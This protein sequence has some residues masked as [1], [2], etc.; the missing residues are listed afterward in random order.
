MISSSRRTTLLCLLLG[1]VTLAVYWPV[2]H[3]RFINYDDPKYVVENPRVASGLTWPNVGWAFQTGH[4]SNWHPLTWLSHMLDVQLF[5][6]DP[7]WHHFTSLLFHTANTLLLFLL[8]Q[9]LTG[10]PWRS[11]SVA[12]LFALHPLHVESVAWVAERKDVLSTF[13]F[14]LTLWAYARYV[15]LQSPKSKVQSPKSVVGGS[16][17]VFYLLALTFFALGLMSKPMLVTLPFLLLLLDYWPLR[18][19]QIENQNSKFR[20]LLPLLLEKLPF[21]VL[22]TASCLVTFVVQ[23]R[24]VA[25][26]EGFPVEDRLINAL[27]SYFRYLAKTVWPANLAPFYPLP[28]MQHLGFDQWPAWLVLAAVFSLAAITGLALRAWRRQPW[29][30]TGWLWFLGTLV[31]VIGLVQAGSQAMADRYSYI[32]LIG[33]FIALVWSAAEL[34]PARSGRNKAGLAAVGVLALA[35]CAALTRKQ[36]N[37]WRDDFALFG[38]TLAVTTENSVPAHYCLGLAF[39]KQG[40]YD[41]AIPHF[42]AVLQLASNMT[43]AHY[44]LGLCL[45]S[46]GKFEEAM[47]AYQAAL[48][49]NPGHA[50]ARNNLAVTLL[51]LGRLDEAAA[52]FAELARLE[53]ASPDPLCSLGGLLLRQRKFAQAETQFAAAVRRQPDFIPALLGLGRALAARGEFA[54]AEARFREVLLLSPTHAEAQADLA[55]AQAGDAQTNA[56]ATWPNEA[57]AKTHEDQGLLYARLG[58]LEEA[59]REF[60]EQL[61]LQPDAQ[62]HYNVALARVMQGNLKEAAT[63]YEEAVKLKPDWPIA[64]NDLAWIRATAPL[65][66]LRDSAAA[67]R[68]AERACQLTQFREPRFVGTLAA[69]YA[70][71]GRFADA[72]TTAEKAI[73]LAT[74]AGQT[75]AAD[76]NR[77][78]IEL[79][80]AAKAYHE[81]EPNAKP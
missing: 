63:H 43:E 31:P 45:T 46:S 80:R 67:V 44:H 51:L 62:A 41:L 68:L 81:P 17:S 22:T 58:K 61:R 79:Y 27:V 5:G 38:H 57:E 28:A 49:V 19:L 66:E 34:F 50:N 78:L 60:Q 42:R 7:G 18:R 33:L 10:A 20:N 53:P 76:K 74:A 56:T 26:V 12:A 15:E 16:W 70:E 11:A 24:A 39:G 25:P 23:R 9:R 71:A 65:V 77:Q 13:F 32:P 47:A 4:A 14:M 48:Q 29:L 72:V 1:A 55:N 21:F 59:V 54:N 69:A 3:H 8:L 64:L 73:D 36:V 75:D 30:A 37:Y 2:I 40:K 6:A 52:Q 35:A